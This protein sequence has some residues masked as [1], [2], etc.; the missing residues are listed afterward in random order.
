MQGLG[1]DIGLVGLLVVGW[2]A[3]GVGLF[4][5]IMRFLGYLENTVYPKKAACVK[6]QCVQ[7][8]HSWSIL[9]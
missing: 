4:M 6:I 7:D 5:G 9:Q 3:L 2:V 1:R 8:E